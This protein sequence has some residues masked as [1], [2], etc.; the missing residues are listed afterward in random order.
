MAPCLDVAIHVLHLARKTLIEPGLQGIE[1]VGWCRRRN[2]GELEA[3]FECMF[4]D[5]CRQSIHAFMITLP[6]RGNEVRR[7]D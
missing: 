3:E 7:D 4:F 6:P 5:T 1:A 2:A